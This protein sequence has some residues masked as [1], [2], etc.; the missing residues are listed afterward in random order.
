MYFGKYLTVPAGTFTTPLA[1]V[2]GVESTIIN[3]GPGADS[4]GNT[5]PMSTWSSGNRFR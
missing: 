3:F 1:V 4:A 5:V 2:E